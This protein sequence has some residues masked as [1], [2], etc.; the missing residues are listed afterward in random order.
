V[1][2]LGNVV[3][4]GRSSMS[5]GA[6]MS[7]TIGIGALVGNVN[8]FRYEGI[9]I[10]YG[11]NGGNDNII[12]IGYQA[13]RT[14]SSNN[15]IH[16]GYQCGTNTSG[17]GVSIGEFSGQNHQ[18]Y[19][20][21]IGSNSGRYN[22]ATGSIAIGYQSGFTGQSQY[23]IA[24]G[25]NAGVTNQYTGS[26]IINASGDILNNSNT[27]TYITP[28]RQLN[29]TD[30]NILMF[31]GTTNELYV[32]SSTKSFIID[33]PDDNN[34]YLIHGCLEGPESSVYY[35]GKGEIINSNDEYDGFTEIQL[36]DYLQKFTNSIET[37]DSLTI[38]ASP[39]FDG[40]FNILSVSDISD[41]K[42][43]VHGGNGK[44]SYMLLG[45]REDIQTTIPKNK[46]INGKGP[47]KYV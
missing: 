27:G 22:Q 1:P 14:F 38:Y 28:I 40:T 17:Y 35:R 32:C 13:G 45:K 4:I 12:N 21:A 37:K 30:G 7:E 24:I 43:T 15:S 41:N 23:S 5:V 36:P 34:Q 16:I 19:G 18:I 20:V 46:N 11:V 33:H 8:R 3:A 25:Y 39:I 10:G 9:G 6:Q 2:I 29:A 47:Y 26:I 31:T 42:F 44:F